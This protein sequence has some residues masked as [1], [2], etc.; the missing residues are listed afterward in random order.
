MV[1]TFS[2]GA[3]DGDREC[4]DVIIVDDDASEANEEF[5]VNLTTSDND[6]GVYNMTTVTIRDNDGKR[7]IYIEHLTT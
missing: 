5:Y 2:S 6:I 7:H 3:N 4:L 1:L